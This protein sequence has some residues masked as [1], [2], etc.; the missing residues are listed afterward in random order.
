MVVPINR[1]LDMWAG[2]FTGPEI[3][4]ELGMS[5]DSVR[6]YVQRAREE[7]DP[8][9]DRRRSGP[10]PLVDIN[11]VNAMREKG[12]PMREIIFATG[13][14]KASVY[15]AMK[16]ASGTPEKR[17]RYASTYF[18]FEAERRGITAD[19]LQSRILKVVRRDRLVN[20]ILDDGVGS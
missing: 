5:A 1:I 12:L 19:Q 11:M 10:S 17:A 13:F 14:S 7:G 3:A 2:S 4:A 18:G 20:A 16:R 9:A 6:K 15:R 8:R